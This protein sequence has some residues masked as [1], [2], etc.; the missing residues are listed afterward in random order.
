ME[1]ATDVV[2]ALGVLLELAKALVS[3][4]VEVDDV[5]RALG[6]TLRGYDAGA[7]A[8]KAGRAVLLEY[9]MELAMTSY[10]PWISK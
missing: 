9:T 4:G 2:K 3:T 1:T 8:S 6:A 5:C 10:T 7:A